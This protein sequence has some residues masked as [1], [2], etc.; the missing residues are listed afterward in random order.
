MLF[1]CSVCREIHEGFPALGFDAPHFY[2]SLSETEKKEI[3]ELSDVFCIIRYTDQT[4]RFIR[5][6]LNQKIIDLPE[7][8]QYGVWVSLSEKSFND[9]KEHYNSVDHLTSYFGYLCN[10]LP[11]YENTLSIKTTVR[12]APDNNRPE[13][14]PHDDQM[15][16]QFVQDYFEGITR[17]KAERRIHATFGTHIC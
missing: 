14:F 8:L 1:N 4:D 11:D 10:Q 12:T 15:N 3:A 9:Y 2:H 16:N 17:E 5:F 7:T 6:V 13:I